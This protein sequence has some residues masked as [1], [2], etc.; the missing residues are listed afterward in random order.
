M[1]CILS[2]LDSLLTWRLAPTGNRLEVPHAV[3]VVT[4]TSAQGFLLP[5]LLFSTYDED[6]DPG[7]RSRLQRLH[8]VCFTAGVSLTWLLNDTARRWASSW[9]ES[10]KSLDAHS[11]SGPVSGIMLCCSIVEVWSPSSDTAL[12][13]FAARWS[14]LPGSQLCFDSSLIQGTLACD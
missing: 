14:S 10:A 9:R 12:G 5:L 8:I 6:V 1:P 3:H 13:V 7:I 4:R 11:L 2:I